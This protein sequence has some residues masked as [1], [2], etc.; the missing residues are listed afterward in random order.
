MAWNYLALWTQ[1]IGL[2]GSID[3]IDRDLLVRK[4]QGR[5]LSQVFRD[6][7]AFSAAHHHPILGRVESCIH[8]IFVVDEAM[9]S[10]SL[11]MELSGFAERFIHR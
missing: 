6:G 8:R 9:V 10:H 4:I 11:S 2:F 5:E 1:R 3:H 7:T